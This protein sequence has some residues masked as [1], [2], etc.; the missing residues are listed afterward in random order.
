MLS[1]YISRYYI[2]CILQVFLLNESGIGVAELAARTCYDSFSNSENDC[3][4]EFDST[5]IGL[6]GGTNVDLINSMGKLFYL[7]FCFN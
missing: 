3:I 2:I 4:R 6:M 7:S 5:T 1:N